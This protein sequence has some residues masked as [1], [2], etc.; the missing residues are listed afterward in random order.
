MKDDMNYTEM[1]SGQE[2]TRIVV[3][4]LQKHKKSDS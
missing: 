2:Q 4:N 1:Q 3:R